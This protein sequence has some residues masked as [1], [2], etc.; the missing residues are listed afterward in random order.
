MQFRSVPF[1]NIVFFQ[2]TGHRLPHVRAVGGWVDERA[3]VV[4][5][6]IGNDWAFRVVLCKTTHPTFI[7]YEAFFFVVLSA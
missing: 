6:A 4:G 3:L 7:S 2:T 5:V 1:H